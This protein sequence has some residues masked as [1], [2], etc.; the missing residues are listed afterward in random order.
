MSPQIL[1]FEFDVYHGFHAGA[2]V[3]KFFVGGVSCKTNQLH[4]NTLTF[5]FTKYFLAQISD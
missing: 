3:L 4:R 2:N 1:T 5:V